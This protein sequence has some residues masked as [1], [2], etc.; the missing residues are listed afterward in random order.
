MQEFNLQDMGR[1]NQFDQKLTKLG[2]QNMKKSFINL[3]LTVLFN[4]YL[5]NVIISVRQRQKEE[6]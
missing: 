1:V 6:S 5:E 3:N 4:N 2:L